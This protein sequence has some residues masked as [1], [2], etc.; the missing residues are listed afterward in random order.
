MKSNQGVVP[1]IPRSSSAMAGLAAHVPHVR[2]PAAASPGACLEEF[3]YMPDD[4]LHLQKGITLT[5]VQA[6]RVMKL[7]KTDTCGKRNSP[8]HL[9][10]SRAGGTQCEG[11]ARTEE[12]ELWGRAEACTDSRKDWCCRS[13]LIPLGH[14]EECGCVSGSGKLDFHFN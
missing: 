2:V 14:K 6:T 7:K 5:P 12:E 4:S 11:G 8:V 9:D 1:H 10:P 13:Y 3:F